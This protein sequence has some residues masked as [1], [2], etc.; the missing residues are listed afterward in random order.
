MKLPFRFFRG[1]FNGPYLYKALTCFNNV[2]KEILDELAYHATVQWKTE[3]EVVKG[4]TPLREEDLMSIS[5]VA[6]LYPNILMVRTNLGSVAFSESR[7][8]AGKQRSERALMNI[9]IGS[10]RYARTGSDEYPDDIV[11]EAS[12]RE[13]ISLV[14]EGR[15]PV[16]YIPEGVSA[17]NEDGTVAWEKLLYEPPDDGT[18]YAPF[19]GDKFLVHEMRFIRD[20]P[21][22]PELYKTLFECL[23]K[24]RRNG[25]TLWAFF[26]VT[27]ILTKG[28]LYNIELVLRPGRYYIL[29]Y[30]V[31]TRSSV[32][33]QDRLVGCWLWLVQDKFKLFVPEMRLEEEEEE[34]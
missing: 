17:F 33:D 31:N 5:R 11:V 12:S 14:P 4:E 18:P 15:E 10:Q 9:S 22:T 7:M 30:T 28:V 23:M 34:E 32:L 25:P 13:R 29:Y 8:S 16:A 24:I 19:Y 27:S 3:A 1:E 26:E 6:G 2:I 20:P 21:L